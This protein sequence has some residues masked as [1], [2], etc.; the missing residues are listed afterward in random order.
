[1]EGHHPV[2]VVMG[3]NAFSHNWSRSSRFLQEFD[4]TYGPLSTWLRIT[5]REASSSREEYR[6][7]MAPV[8]VVESF[9]GLYE[10]T[11]IVK[12]ETGEL[13]SITKDLQNGRLGLRGIIC[14]TCI[15]PLVT[16]TMGP[17]VH[18]DHN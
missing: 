6:R 4:T 7:T 3:T 13:Y 9:I 2:L 17:G 14:E 18:E 11:D 1:M 10:S 8:P 15:H 12:H 5:D 16:C